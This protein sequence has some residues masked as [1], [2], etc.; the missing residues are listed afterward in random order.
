[1]KNLMKVTALVAAMGLSMAANAGGYWGGNIGISPAAGND[2]TGSGN[3]A[4]I[5]TTSGMGMGGILGYRVNQYMATEASF[6]LL[7]LGWK[8]GVSDVSADA[9]SASLLGYIP[10]SNTVET[11][12]KVSYSNSTVMYTGCA[13]CKSTQQSKSAISYGLGVEMGDKT[14]RFRLGVDHYDLSAY[15]GATLNTNYYSGSIIVPF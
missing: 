15:A 14:L 13:G 7:G 3:S 8:S 10:V 11:F 12:G 9:F 2:V 4:G 5:T 6:T 1:M